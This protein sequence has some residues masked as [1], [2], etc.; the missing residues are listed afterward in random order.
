MWRQT[1]PR[2][3]GIGTIIC[4]AMNLRLPQEAE[5]ALRAEAQR[6]GRSQ[7]EIVRAALDRYLSA[8]PPQSFGET[9]PL[10]LSGKVL[11]PRIPYYKVTPTM[12]LPEGMSSSLELLDRDDRF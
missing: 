1:V 4:M 7:Q 10:L 6:S 3:R 5:N 9:D 8:V 2:W 12:S 11:P